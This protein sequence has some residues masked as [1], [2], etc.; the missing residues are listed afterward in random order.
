M[1]NDNRLLVLSTGVD[2]RG[3]KLENTVYCV[4]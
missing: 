2:F 1:N 3:V 4:Q